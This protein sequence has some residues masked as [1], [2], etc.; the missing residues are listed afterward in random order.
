[1]SEFQTVEFSVDDDV[2]LVTL[3]RPEAANAM[4]TRMGEELLAVLGG[5]DSPVAGARCVLLT[6]AGDR[7]FCAG[8]DLKERNGMTDAQWLQQH[9]VFETLALALM[10]LQVPLIGAINGAAF[11]GGMEITLA[12]DFVYAARTARFALTETTLGILPGTC[13]T[14]NL[15]RA[16]G[17]RR[18]KEIILTGRPFSAEQAQAW[19]L[20]NE[21]CDADD[22]LPKTRESAA[23]I[24]GNGPIAVREAKRAMNHAVHRDLKAGYRVELAAYSKVVPTADRREGILAFNEKRKPQFNGD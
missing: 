22:L 10:D 6:G 12:C 18:A 15:P 8:A 19:G 16:V 21:V 5:S 7:A 3:N 14:Q 2:A 23:A 11:G 24:A 13:G 4:N 17:I 20:V 9:A 1:M